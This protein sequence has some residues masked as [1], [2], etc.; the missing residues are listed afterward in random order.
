MPSPPPSRVRPRAPGP[1]AARPRAC[2]RVRPGVAGASAAVATASSRARS[3]ARNSV[4]RA[5]SCL[6]SVARPASLSSVAACCRSVL[7]LRGIGLGPG[8][9]L[10]RSRRAA[11]RPGSRRPPAAG[12]PSTVRSRRPMASAQPSGRVR[13][14]T[15]ATS[16]GSAA[17]IGATGPQRLGQFRLGLLDDLGHRGPEVV[18]T[19]EGGRELGRAQPDPLGR[20]EPRDGAQRGR[21]LVGGHPAEHVGSGQDQLLAGRLRQ[22]HLRSPRRLLARAHRSSLRR[23][24]VPPQFRRTPLLPCGHEWHGTGSGCRP[25]LDELDEPLRDTTFTVVD[26]ETTGGSAA[27]DAITE[28]GAVRVRAGEVDRRVPD[29]GQPGRADRAVRRRAHRHHR[30]HGRR[31]RRRSGR[32]CRRS[33]SSRAAACSSP[34]TRRSTWASCKAAAAE[35]GT[36]VA[37]LRRRRHGRAGAARPDPRRGAQLPPRLAGDVLPGHDRRPITE[38]W[39]TRAPPSTC[40]T[41]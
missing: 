7:G 36:A 21:D 8:A 29:P 20:R 10:A 31:R 17:S 2:S 38:R 25:A 19:V 28:I 27:A 3:A 33:S 26:L 4:V 37:G 35:H 6:R 14:S 13:Y 39:T 34:T 40:C 11:P 15:T 30:R 22:H 41:G 24:G 32:Y 9:Q 23:R 16:S 5:R 18:V 1:G 12:S